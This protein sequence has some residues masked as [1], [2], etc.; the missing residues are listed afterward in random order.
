MHPFR[1]FLLATTALALFFAE[2]RTEEDPFAAGVRPTPFLPAT[3]EQARFHLPP[4]F[5][6]ELVASEPAIQKPLNMAFDGRGRL[7]IT[8]TVEYPYAAPPD[9]PGRDTIKILEDTNGDG[10]ADKITTFA[11]GLNIPIGILPLDRGEVIVYS[12]PN[13]WLLRDTDGDDKCDERIPLLGPFGFERDT[14]GMNNAFRRGFDG[15]IYACHGFNNITNVKAADGSSVSMQSGNTYR[16]RFDPKN[17]QGTTRIEQFTWGQV[18][19]FGMTIDPYFN[20]FT[21]DCHS[22]PITHLI[23]GGYYPSF[24]KPDDGLGFTPAMMEHLHGSTAICGISFL[25]GTAFPPEFRGNLI[26]GNVMTSRVNRDNLAYRGGYIQCAE[27]PDFI[28][29]DDPWFRPVDIQEAA[30]GSLYVA[31]FYNRIIGH[32]EVP[33]PHPGRDR[34]SGRIWR[35]SYRGEN[36]SAH[37]P[38]APDLEKA[39]VSDLWD[40]IGHPNLPYRM[41]A[42]EELVTRGSKLS[43]EALVRMI[44]DANS[45]EKAIAVTHALWVNERQGRLSNEVLLTAMVSPSDLIRTHVQKILSERPTWTEFE[46]ALAN[47]AVADESGFVAR[48]AADA[49]GRHPSKEHLSALTRSYCARE[50][51][52]LLLRHNLKIA[53]R[54]TLQAPGAFAQLEQLD[55]PKQQRGEIVGLAAVAGVPEASAYIVH[56]LDTSDLP[57]EEWFGLFQKA[58]RVIEPTLIDRAI[59]L[60]KKRFPSD[61]TRRMEAVRVMRKSLSDRGVSALGSLEEWGIELASEALSLRDDRIGWRSTFSSGARALANETR[62]CEGAE[63]CVMF[64]SL[65]L[66]EEATCVVRSQS[67]VCPKTL[68]FWIAGHRGQPQTEGHN[69]CGVRLLDAETGGVIKEILAP[70]RDWG[71]RV[72]WDLAEFADKNV[73]LEIFDQDSGESY[74]WVAVGGFSVDKLNPSVYD[75]LHKTGSQLCEELVAKRLEPML[76]DRLLN[77][78]PQWEVKLAM[79]RAIAKIRGISLGSTLV[80]GIQLTESESVEKALLAALAQGTQENVREALTALFRSTSYTAQTYLTNE[81]SASTEGVEVIFDLIDKGVASARL[82]TEPAIAQR[83]GVF[84][85]EVIR[86][87]LA[88][89]TESLPERNAELEGRVAEI[90]EKG[91]RHNTNLERGRAMFTKH[92]A[93]CHQVA[94][95]GKV[96]GPQLDGIGGRGLARIIEDVVDPNRNVDIAFRVATIVTKEGKVLLGLPRREVGPQL[97]YVDPQGNEQSILLEDI[98]ELKQTGLSL[99]P[100]NV[101]EIMK[102]DELLDLLGYLAT[103]RAAKPLEPSPESSGTSARP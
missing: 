98:E 80:R 86:E 38:A 39:T 96:I 84:N 103:L 81:L 46:V 17:P 1:T 53:I 11:D 31:D 33:L 14:H 69:G 70:R 64:S 76:A 42:S 56:S 40:A 50:Q 13:I 58:A 93:I 20:L 2:A 73:S 77:T 100:S 85:T 24:G 89:L 71:L 7:W 51:D 41:R 35:I 18:N 34:T 12:I 75:N 101:S 49:L 45:D 66:G 43:A 10:L 83:L 37:P 60:L 99:M 9:R 30:D 28:A 5:K 47:R 62:R 79:A 61:L 88:K 90:R 63:P 52:D 72:D 92:C 78:E 48:A 91:P 59:S 15:W 6:I 87:R 4:G 22:K 27:A 94:G 68:T 26:S 54:N 65:P 23:R 19:P 57:D 32:Y 74:A 44:R 55:F 8:D 16:F 36:A 29:C 67:F 82:A 21:A 25:T 102:E 95:Q 3:E 97:V